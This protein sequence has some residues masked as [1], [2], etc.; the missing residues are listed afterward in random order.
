[1][2]GAL[3]H[4]APGGH[5][6]GGRRQRCGHPEDHWARASVPDTDQERLPADLVLHPRRAAHGYVV[7]T[8]HAQE[9]SGIVLEYFIKNERIGQ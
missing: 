8:G 4:H 1:M 6:V 9:T 5:A 2:C 3:R 7:R